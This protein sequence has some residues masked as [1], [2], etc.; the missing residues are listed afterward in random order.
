MEIASGRARKPVERSFAGWQGGIIPGEGT[1]VLTTYRRRSLK[2]V[3]HRF[4]AVVLLPHSRQ[5][6]LR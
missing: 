2:V 3:S 6:D 5:T 1:V 4:G